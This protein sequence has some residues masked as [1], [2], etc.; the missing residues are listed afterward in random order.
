MNDSPAN[1]GLGVVGVDEAAAQDASP[2][3][4][5]NPQLEVAEVPRAR[6]RQEYREA[7]HNPDTPS[8]VKRA[9]KQF[10]HG[11]SGGRRELRLDYM[12]THNIS[13]C[14]RERTGKPDK[15]MTGRQRKKARKAIRRIRK[16][17]GE[18]A[19]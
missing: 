1:S 5:A 9:I 8:P 4:E 18:I 10:L 13:Q 15:A 16:T 19:A 2:A 17:L 7:L 11:A 14:S 3:S 12:T 6:T